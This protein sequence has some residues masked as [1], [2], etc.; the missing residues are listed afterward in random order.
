MAM[1][2]CKNAHPLADINLIQLD[3][4]KFEFELPNNTKKLHDLKIVI[5]EVN[6]KII[7]L[8]STDTIGNNYMFAV[9]KYVVDKKITTDSESI[10]SFSVNKLK[11]KVSD[12][13]SKRRS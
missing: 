8:A 5:Q 11:N 1:A 3:D 7:Y 10:F 6:D 9:R 4:N 13:K 12:L 2:S